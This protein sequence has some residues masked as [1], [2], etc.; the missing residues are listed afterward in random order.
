MSMYSG[1]I[2]GIP[3]IN[4]CVNAYIQQMLGCHYSPMNTFSLMAHGHFKLHIQIFG[5]WKHSES[6]IF[7]LNK[8][9][10][11]SWS[12]WR[13]AFR[14][15]I[16][17]FYFFSGETCVV[18]LILISACPAGSSGERCEETCDCNHLAITG[19]ECVT[20][21]RGREENNMASISSS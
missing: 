3:Q 5:I 11:F 9:W 15:I 17:P 10:L 6:H 1:K 8:Y 21:K 16:L 12:V 18:C 20:V 4:S 19:L 2:S 14:L 13:I 7:S